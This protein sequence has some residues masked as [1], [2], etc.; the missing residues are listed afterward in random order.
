MRQYLEIKA[1]NPEAILF[2][3]MGDFYEMFFED[4][5]LASTLLGIALTSRDREREIPM[6]GVPYHAASAYIAKLVKAGYGV[7][8]C[9]QVT[10]PKDAKGLV[11]RAVARLITPG[12]ALD[13][14]ILEPKANNFIASAYVASR[15]CG[16]AYMDASTGEFSVTELADPTML[17]EEIR[18]LRPL[19]V[20]INEEAGGSIELGSTPV[21]KI[22]ALTAGYFDY[23]NC[24]ERLTRHYEV[25]SLDGFGLAGMSE[26]VSAAGALLAYVR[27]TQKSEA[28]HIRPCAPYLTNDWLV[29]DHSTCRNLELTENAS[30]GSRSG[31][32]LAVI[33]M[34]RTSMGARR[35]RSWLLHPLKD[36]LRIAERHDAIDELLDKRSQRERLH[37]LL[38]EISDIERLIAR[39]AM[40]R[41]GPRDL[42]SLKA[43]LAVIPRIKSVAAY[44]ETR[45][46]RDY[47]GELDPCLD[48]VE[49]IERSINPA[50]PP[51]LR[52]GGVIR[53]GYN[54]PLDELREI[55]S[56]G[57]ESIARIE[58]A[59]RVATGI[60]S[61]KVGYNRVFGYYI[62]VTKANS[63][64]MPA[65]YTRKQTL[66]NAERFITPGLKEWEEKVLTAEDRA[67]AIEAELFTGVLDA[68]AHHINAVQSAAGKVATLD[69]L[70]SLT[71][72]AEEMNYARPVIDDG[73]AIIIE[74]G[75]HPVVEHNVDG[76]FNANDLRLDASS[77]QIIILTGPNMAGKS[78]YL[79]QCALIVIM[80]QMDSFVPAGR[81][82]IGLADR[83]FTRVGASDDLARGHS[84]FM[85]E[86]NETATILNNATSRSLVILDEI[87]RGTSTFDGLSIAWAVVEHLHDRAGVRPKT[88]FATHYHE[89]TELSLT[90]ERVKN[91]NMS[92]KEW[93]GRIIFL[94]KVVPG[95]ASRSYGISVARLAGIPDPVI[96][97]AREILK[98]LE[99]GE[100]NSAG[101]PRLS[102]HG[103]GRMDMPRQLP[104]LTGPDELRETLRGVDVESTTPL[105]AL[106]I[107]ARMKELAE[108]G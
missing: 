100:L 54:A 83:V 38:H 96:T 7:A 27:D 60:G 24:L 48:A 66:A 55:S 67:L 37:G 44:M 30:T 19:E 47:A 5:K 50:P 33:D 105:E 17:V 20:V 57:K 107:L 14:D 74:A 102:A 9:E 34:T 97:R 88:I 104:L 61:L 94:R 40:R 101:L 76:A 81:A 84:T 78:T 65:H 64:A 52:D 99:S 43:S 49:L 11:Q 23:R 51:T 8:V 95:G 108:D 21:K 72:A 98:T 39:V 25:A 36:A 4:A 53:S 26:G 86:M 3:R 91:Y 42:V 106:K 15:R 46:L 6:C 59:E 82:V 56:G 28:A 75:R 79:R 1:A 45:L 77:D 93:A 12:T 68:L 32:L 58:A 35:L 10:D 89:L 41:A 69:C 16:F 85:V 31:T 63:A 103:Q 73:D 29:M 70:V 2:F 71:L 22:T 90:K 13:D 80:A 18:R 87:G 62:E 92:V